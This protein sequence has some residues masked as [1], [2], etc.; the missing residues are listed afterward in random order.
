MRLRLRLTGGGL[1]LTG[2]STGSATIPVSPPPSAQALLV[3]DAGDPLVTD[4]NEPLAM[5]PPHGQ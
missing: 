3:T 2:S 1:R 5:E 4:R